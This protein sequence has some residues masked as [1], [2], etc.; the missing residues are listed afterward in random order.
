M[1][2]KTRMGPSGSAWKKSRTAET[3][4]P[5]NATPRLLAILSVDGA[6][7]EITHC[8][9]QPGSLTIGCVNMWNTRP[10]DR[11]HPPEPAHPSSGS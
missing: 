4:G 9:P 7:L 8:Q 6:Y 2:V 1:S 5:L 10:D 11:I 3:P